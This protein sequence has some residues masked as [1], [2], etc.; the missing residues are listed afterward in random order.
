MFR[1][2]CPGTLRMRALRGMKCR[3]IQNGSHIP[4]TARS[5]YFVKV[6]DQ[7]LQNGGTVGFVPAHYIDRRSKLFKEQSNVAG[8]VLRRV[9]GCV[10][11]GHGCTCS[12]CVGESRIKC[13]TRM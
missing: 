4:E 11:C 13:L 6:I 3:L 12:N 8:A 7:E 5:V 10:D 2:I 1:V 9:N